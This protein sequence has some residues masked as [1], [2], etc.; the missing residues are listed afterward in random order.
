VLAAA[1]SLHLFEGD[2]RAL[3]RGRGPFHERARGVTATIRDAREPDA[4]TE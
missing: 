3:L 4:L 1:P 2:L